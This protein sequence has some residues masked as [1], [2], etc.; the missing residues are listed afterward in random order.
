MG[1]RRAVWPGAGLGRCGGGIPRHGVLGCLLTR[2]DSSAC[3]LPLAHCAFRSAFVA[4]I[5]ALTCA[6]CGVLIQR[7]DSS[8]VLHH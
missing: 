7:R 8:L 1:T 4:L 3:C 2:R 5:C 6:V